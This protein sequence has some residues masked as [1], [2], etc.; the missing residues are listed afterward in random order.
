MWLSP[1]DFRSHNDTSH[2]SFV[3]HLTKHD[4]TTKCDKIDVL[5]HRPPTKPS[6]QSEHHVMKMMKM[7]GMHQIESMET[8]SLLLENNINQSS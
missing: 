8:I 3:S 5:L 7:K 6:N 1:D 2:S 4:V